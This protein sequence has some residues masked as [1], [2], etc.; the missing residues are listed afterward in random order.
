MRIGGPTSRVPGGSSSLVAFILSVWQ[1][2]IGL[3][4]AHPLSAVVSKKSMRHAGRIALLSL[5]FLPLGNMSFFF[6]P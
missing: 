6:F 3:Q 5:L 2:A 4:Q 1:L